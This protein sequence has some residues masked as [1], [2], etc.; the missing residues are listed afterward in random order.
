MCSGT[1]AGVTATLACA[2]MTSSCGYTIKAAADV[3]PA[4]QFANYHTFF[5]LEGHPSGDP[6]RDQRVADAVRA[7]LMDKGWEEVAPGEGRAVVVVHAATPAAHSSAT[8]YDGWGGWRWDW[9]GNTKPTDYE[10]GTV[11][12]DIFDAASKVAIWRGRTRRVV[13]NDV[14]QKAGFTDEAMAG[15]FK[16]FPPGQ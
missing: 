13:T 8:F 1:S 3:N 6:F 16:A 9:A 12:V 15:M 14:V 5:M 11:V 2:L 4:V 10:A 7:A